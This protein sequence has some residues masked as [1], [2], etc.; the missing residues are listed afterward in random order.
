MRASGPFVISMALKGRQVRLDVHQRLRVDGGFGVSAAAQRG[1]H[2]LLGR[3]PVALQE[4]SSH[5]DGQVLGG[6]RPVLG[7]KLLQSEHVDL[8]DVGPRSL[9]D[10]HG[11]SHRIRRL[12]RH[13]ILHDLGLI[14]AARNVEALDPLQIGLPRHRIVEVLG[15]EGPPPGL[16]GQDLFFDLAG[17]DLMVS[18]DL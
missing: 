8:A 12:G 2:L 11:K 10:L 1:G 6:R 17:R 18:R 9:A 16:G 14:E 13:L 3:R 15:R 4:G 7:R 5:C